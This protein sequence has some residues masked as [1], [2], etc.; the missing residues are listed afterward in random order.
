MFYIN[1]QPLDFVTLRPSGNWYS[2]DDEIKKLLSNTWRELEQRFFAKNLPVVFKTPSIRS[3]QGKGSGGYSYPRVVSYKTKRSGMVIIAWADNQINEGGHITYKPLTRKIWIN[4]KSLTL[5]ENDI[6]EA[7]FMYLFNPNMRTE[8]NPAGITY[9]EDKEQEA[10][11]YE[12]T[13]QSSA[14]IS[15]WLYR[16][17]SPF[18]ADEKTIGTLCLAWGI[19]PEGRSITYRKQLLAEAIKKAERKNDLE[20]NL[21]AFNTHCEKLKDGDDTDT[22]IMALIQKCIINR[23]IRFDEDKISWMLLGNEGQLLKTICKVPPQM[24]S[25]AKQI[26]KRHLVQHTDDIH[27]LESSLSDDATPSSV[28]ECILSEPLPDIITD[29][30]IVNKM[31]WIDRKAIYKYFGRSSRGKTADQIHPELIELLIVQKRPVK[32]RVV[33]RD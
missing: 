6:E 30:H 2:G 31:S 1:H 10:R 11:Q 7:I 29:D 24:I 13:E 26:L 3:G 12:E 22:E 18:Y 5:S 9:L 20:F 21:A 4:E 33:K 32:Y 28:D 23:V 17:E 14:V 25:S 15:Y 19:N 27:T 16:K 8:K